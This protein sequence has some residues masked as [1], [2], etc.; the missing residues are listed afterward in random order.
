MKALALLCLLLS[1]CGDSYL[2]VGPTDRTPAVV[3]CTSWQAMAA[4]CITQGDCSQAEAGHL[5]GLTNY[6]ERTI[7]LLT[8][9]ADTLTADEALWLAHELQHWADRFSGGSMW[10]LL[11]MMGHNLHPIGN[12][13]P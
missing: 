5:R 2:R 13:T 8:E 7:Y 9:S 3:F 10:K 6:P 4:H 1:G 11:A 12:E